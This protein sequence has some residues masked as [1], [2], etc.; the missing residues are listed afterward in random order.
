M[1]DTKTIRTTRRA[2]LRGAGAATLLAGQAFGQAPAVRRKVKI[3]YWGWADNPV[4]QKMSVD[5]VDMFNKS[6]GFV[7]VELDA[8]SLVQELRKKVVVAA[9][10]GAG[11]DVAGT[12]Q[13]HVQDWFESEILHPVD[14]F[15]AKWPERTDYF[16]TAVDAMRSKPGQPVLYMANSILPYILYYRAD[17]FAEA[18]LEPPKTY[19]A[20]IAAA[21]ALAQ[22]PNRIG[23]ALRG[24]D[25]F[26]VQP[27]EPI[28]A[29]AGVKIVDEKGNV[30]FDSPAAIAVTE[31][32][33]GMYT[34]DKSAQATAVNDRYPQ[35]FALMEQGKGALWI[36]GTHANPQLNAALGDR[37]QPIRTPNVGAK[38]FTLANPE[39]LFMLK[40]CKE[41]E[42]A[43]EFMTHMCS[44]EPARI[45]TQ[46][47]GLLPVRQTLANEPGIQDNRF[48]KVAIAEAA[49]WWMPPF[50]HKNWT[51]YQD[52]I[53][54][55]WQQ[56]L[57][58]EITVKQFHE[59][60][61]KF[62]RGQA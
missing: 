42:A 58:E 9:A 55:Y 56:A 4:H 44:G 31:R 32:W 47:R 1:T 8:T 38:P 33:V 59:Q 10:A 15:F 27:I 16:A 11:P 62:L 12:V 51:N 5:S 25:Y 50:A 49:N 41:K 30:D 61:A 6:N 13:T 3:S 37:I 43:F 60:A 39:G 40:A 28:W 46:K 29:S 17:W 7:T 14:E 48:F 26:A 35:L 22:P 34:K 53:A 18:K 36:Y 20:M 21:K 57:R 23:Y 45:F 24:M 52:K 19:E 54:P 2:A